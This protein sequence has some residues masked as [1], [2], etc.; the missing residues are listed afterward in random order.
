MVDL[1]KDEDNNVEEV[2]NELERKNEKIKHQSLGKTKIKSRENQQK[3]EDRLMNDE[4]KAK[5]LLEKQIEKVEEEIK[6]ICSE[7][8][9]RLN[10]IFKMKE[11]IEGPRKNSQEAQAVTDPSNGELVVSGSEIR[12]VGLEYCLETL[13]GYCG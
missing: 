4:E 3:K 8:N 10:T 7:S 9:G 6:K 12:R 2:M 13:K 5:E 11:M 1:I